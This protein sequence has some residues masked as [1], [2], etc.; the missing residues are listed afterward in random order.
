MPITCGPTGST[1]QEI[2]DEINRLGARPISHIYT[3]TAALA[4]QPIT[5]TPSKVLVGN[6]W[7]ALRA[8]ITV[9]NAE[10]FTFTKTGLYEISFNV[11]A[12]YDQN[13]IINLDG[14][15]NG[16]SM[17]D[18]RGISA[19]GNGAANPH[20]FNWM[21]LRSFN[22]G[23]VLT[24]WCKTDTGTGSFIVSMSAVQCREI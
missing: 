14:Y 3:A 1:G 19:T 22:I 20:V 2:A 15:I 10:G 8:G 18:G 4:A 11:S 24:F 7:Q 23:D 5:T 9:T 21:F 6:T 12:F 16:V 13:E 17:S